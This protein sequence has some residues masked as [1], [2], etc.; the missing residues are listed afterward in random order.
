MT[1]LYASFARCARSKTITYPKTNPS[2]VCYSIWRRLTSNLGTCRI[3]CEVGLDFYERAE[4]PSSDHNFQA[5]HVPYIA[6][7]TFPVIAQ[8]RQR[9][10]TSRC[11]VLC[12]NITIY[13]KLL[14]SYKLLSVGHSMKTTGSSGCCEYFNDPMCQ[15]AG[16]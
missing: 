8:F 15:T 16:L 2:S 12:G 11:I 4:Q 3:G 13:V 7:R 14:I 10:Q 5:I 6:L 1:H 9:F